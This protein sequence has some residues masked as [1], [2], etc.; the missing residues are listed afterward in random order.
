MSAAF[1]ALDYHPGNRVEVAPVDAYSE[2]VVQSRRG[3][4]DRPMT[5]RALAFEASSHSADAIATH[6]VFG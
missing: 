1:E 4:S 5:S 2:V 3:D 6:E